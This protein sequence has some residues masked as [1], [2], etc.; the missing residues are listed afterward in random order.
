MKSPNA[1][2]DIDLV[3]PRP[4]SLVESLRAF[5]Y[6]LPTALADLADN[7]I[8]ANAK[9]IRLHFCW[10]GSESAIALADDGLGMSQNKLVEAMRVG[11]TNPLLDRDQDDFGR[12]GL[13]LKTASFSQCRRVTVISRQRRGPANIR[14]WDIDYVAKTNE[15]RLLRDATPLAQTID[16]KIANGS[17]GTVVVWEKLDRLAP[18]KQVN[19]EYSEDAFLLRAEQVANHFS[20]VFHRLMEGPNRIS[21]FINDKL[22]Q[23]W[24]PFL[25]DQQATKKLP[26]EKLFFRRKLISIQPF[27][28][29]HRSKIDADTHSK[30]AGLRGWNAQ[31]GFYVYRNRRLIV[32]GDWLGLKGWKQEEHYKLARIQV[33]LPNSM[34]H[35]WELD[36]T[37]SKARPPYLL[38]DELTRIGEYTRNRARHVYAYRGAKLIPNQ[39]QERVFLWEQVSQ[40]N[41]VSYR[42]NR[43]HPLVQKVCATSS[44]VPKVSALFRLI[45][46]TMPIPLITITEREKPDLT[47][48]PFE[49]TKD[50]ETL[51]VMRQILAALRSS[52]LSK[53]DSIK[54]LGSMEP[55]PQFPQLLQAV[56]EEDIL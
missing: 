48:G 3:P 21:F 41:R 33:D 1:N 40:H 4:G 22:I 9:N 38:R 44:D 45:E 13:G 30:A 17:Q 2:D 49:T 27:V 34:D 55:F 10:R 32:A 35:E 19:D 42:I 15:W 23:P 16:N 29:P 28:L 50:K 37:K 39:D 54:R 47:T 25:I 43:E 18:K 11:S 56:A 20:N 46:E 53:N 6:D 12:F 24:D 8:F 31:Q 7:S 26:L 5:G 52:G 51:E 36:V 14:C